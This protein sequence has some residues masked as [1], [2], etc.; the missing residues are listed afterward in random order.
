MAALSSN[1]V[2][3][4]VSGPQLA[5]VRS[6]AEGLD[7]AAAWQRY[8]APHEAPD[9]RRARA[10]LQRLLDDL[11]TL[12]RSQSR[13]QVAALLRRDP[14]A[15]VDAPGHRPSL[16]AFREQQPADFYSED[17]L[18]E[19]YE[20][21]F[22]RVDARSTARRRQRLRERLLQALQWFDT[23]VAPVPK[24]SDHAQAWLDERWCARL[25]Q[26]GIS[27]LADLQARV[28]A[29]GQHWHRG[30]PRL[31]K[32]GAARLAQWW[33]G[34]A[35]SL[36]PWPLP[37]P[38]PQ[39]R[40]SAPCFGLVPLERLQTRPD[41]DGRH[42]SN[43]AP[44]HLAGVGLEDDLQ[45]VRAWLAE[46]A[47]QPHTWRSYRREAERWLLWAWL[48]RGC[49][50]S[51]LTP[52]DCAAYLAFVRN[53]GKSWTAPRQVQ[54][55]QADW[56]PFEAGLSDRSV[57]VAQ[58]ILQALGNWLQG[59]RYW[60]CNPWSGLN[61]PPAASTTHASAERA[62]SGGQ[63]R[64]LLRW[65]QERPPSPAR[66]RQLCALA[67][68]YG[69][70]LRVS[71]MAR[72]RADWLVAL[73]GEHPG[74]DTTAWILR[75]TASDGRSRDVPL[76]A[77]WLLAI[78]AE[79]CA[80]PDP[81]QA[82]TRP[83]LASWRGGQ[84]LSAHRIYSLLRALFAAAAHDLAGVSPG[85]ADKLQRASTHWLRRSWGLHSLA[86]GVPQ[87]LVQA[88]LGHASAAITAEYGACIQQ[89]SA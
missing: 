46:H 20:A 72:A 35:A 74:P 16:E 82:A 47:A 26:A 58:A 60:L 88:R 62:I 30:V 52:D 39:P 73:P 40:S 59:Q 3:K 9:M 19:L 75:V 87:A 65:V 10:E 6:W 36:G 25:A 29:Q 18:V 54:R 27:T 8:L 44:I 1:W 86:D 21:E 67:L 33:D 84:A 76:T 13:P 37:E 85:L 31:G 42:G 17:E 45:A 43:R 41:L 53:P 5:F 22:G 64:L 24:L 69:C 63:W 23:L 48:E 38:L 83:L 81:E 12:A 57:A 61:K 34:H 66:R 79:L 32:Q 7:V 4:G 80:R 55:W 15:I 11:R 71:E 68:A 51:S 89:V 70:G 28:Q 49:A 2:S 50:L 77:E 78:Q 14:A 56:R